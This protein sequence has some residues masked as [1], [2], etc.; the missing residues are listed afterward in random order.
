[1]PGLFLSCLPAADAL[2][3]IGAAP[4]NDPQSSTDGALPAAAEWRFGVDQW[5][6]W[7][8]RDA[9]DSNPQAERLSG[10]RGKHVEGQHAAGGTGPALRVTAPSRQPDALAPDKFALLLNG[11]ILCTDQAVGRRYRCSIPSIT[12]E[13][14]IPSMKRQNTRSGFDRRTRDMGPPNKLAERRHRPERRLP[15]LTDMAFEEFEAELAAQGKQASAF[16]AS[17]SSSAS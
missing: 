7:R 12:A 4:A 10:S 16:L 8:R 1:M 13:A 15:E 9:T 11:V 6:R 5:H 3:Q 2:R 17:S 14:D